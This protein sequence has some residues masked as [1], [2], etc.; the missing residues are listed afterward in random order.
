MV[1]I[2]AIAVFALLNVETGDV[3]RLEGTVVSVG[4]ETSPPYSLPRQQ[5][6]V[7]FGNDINVMVEVPRHIVINKDDKVLIGRSSRLF[8]GHQYKFLKKE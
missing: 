4:M 3:E 6:T 5:V 1:G 7:K 8:V 2:F